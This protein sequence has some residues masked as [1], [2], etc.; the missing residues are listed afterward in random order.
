MEQLA[1]EYAGKVTFGKLNVDEN[2]AVS[3]SFGIQSIPTMIVFKNGLAVDG[4]VGAL[5]KPQIEK[6]FKPYLTA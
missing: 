1:H 2:P 6:K 5:P 3:H 4:L